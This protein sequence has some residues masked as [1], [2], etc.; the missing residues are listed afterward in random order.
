VSADADRFPD[1]APLRALAREVR[2]FGGVYQ[3]HSGRL[4]VYLTASGDEAQ[5]RPAVGRWLVSR[6]PRGGP[7]PAIVFQRGAYDF[8]QLAHWRGTL[9]PDLFGIRGVQSLDLDEAANR[10][11]IGVISGDSR[12]PV[13]ALLRRVGVPEA[14]AL[15][16]VEDT[17]MTLVDPET[18]FASFPGYLDEVFDSIPGGAKM[19]YVTTYS[20][21]TQSRCT[22]TV[23]VRRNGERMLLTASHC[24]QRSWRMD[25]TPVHQPLSDD[26]GSYRAG[27]EAVD[28][29][30]F[31]CISS[32][33][34]RRADAALIRTDPD[35]PDQL[36]RIARTRFYASSVSPDTLGSRQID[37]NNPFFVLSGTGS[38]TTGM[39]VY[40]MG[41]RTGWTRG[42]VTNT[43]VITTPDDRA[44]VYL[45][46][47]KATVWVSR[48]DSGG[49]LFAVNPDGTVSLLGIVSART[50]SGSYSYHSPMS[51][52]FQDLGT[53]E[54]IVTQPAPPTDE[55][56][57]PDAGGGCSPPE[58]VC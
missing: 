40:K 32:L 47:I 48:G 15:I 46:Q 26:F 4:V 43:C 44:G 21:L 25:A 54:V 11:R 38:A 36:G 8:A 31:H 29:G 1:E 33:P 58:A 12:D 49:P 3:D 57:P 52:A 6:L 5:A 19:T 30:G 41:V 2:G 17:V 55:E 27:V 42:I 16:S 9:L 18:Q 24:T 23:P 10:L 35:R 39:I 51:G 13:R 45:C 20:P 34:C 14:A 7:S 50:T 53:F 37:P 28:Y 22:I 56:P